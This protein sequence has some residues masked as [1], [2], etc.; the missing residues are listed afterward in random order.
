LHLVNEGS[1]QKENEKKVVVLTNL[2]GLSLKTKRRLPELI[3]SI[4]VKT[5]ECGF[6]KL[7][8][9]EIGISCFLEE[10]E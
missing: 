7:I 10:R 5:S 3:L 2:G 1:L 4:D 9:E 6:L 8:L